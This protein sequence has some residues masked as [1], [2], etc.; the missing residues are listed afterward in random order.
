MAL[1]RLPFIS[2]QPTDASEEKTTR[3]EGK[4]KST[5]NGKYSGL[6]VCGCL[7]SLSH[8]FSSFFPF[9]HSHLAPLPS[10]A[11]A[12][13][14]SFR[15]FFIALS[16]SWDCH[17][18]FP[19]LDETT[20]QT[21]TLSLCLCWTDVNRALLLTVLHGRNQAPHGTLLLQRTERDV[22]KGNAERHREKTN[23]RAIF[24]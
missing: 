21:S 18:R 5:T 14:L 20:A 23:E 16:L 12:L 19:Y 10:T 22:K 11:L 6:L 8:S 17:C 13:I 15:V 7:C 9:S 4:P 1:A 3:G 2:P 24:L